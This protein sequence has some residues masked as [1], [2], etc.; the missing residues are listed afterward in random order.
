MYIVLALRPIL[1]PKVFTTPVLEML[2]KLDHQDLTEDLISL[3]PLEDASY[4]RKLIAFVSTEASSDEI[5]SGA[6]AIEALLKL[7]QAMQAV[8][9]LH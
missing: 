5:R 6:A 3:L 7:G 4:Q 8:W 1:G 9:S 2:R